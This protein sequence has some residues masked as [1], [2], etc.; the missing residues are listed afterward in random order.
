MM[1]AGS[2]SGIMLIEAHQGNVWDIKEPETDHLA[3]SCFLFLVPQRTSEGQNTTLSLSL[4][5]YNPPARLFAARRAA[6]RIL[7]PIR[8]EG[9]RVYRERRRW[10]GGG[11]G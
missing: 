2:T 9:I 8:S 11:G 5:L 3:A 1:M 10:G 4:S 7:H 6:T